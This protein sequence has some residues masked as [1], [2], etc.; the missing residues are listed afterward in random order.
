M[1]HLLRLIQAKDEAV[2]MA[3]MDVNSAWND[4]EAAEL[5][6]LQLFQNGEREGLVLDVTA[7]K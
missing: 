4:A 5:E 2:N 1:Y 3:V 6:A 7:D